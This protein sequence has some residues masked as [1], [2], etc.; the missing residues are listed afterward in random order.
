MEWWKRK[1][2]YVKKLTYNI[3][4]TTLKIITIKIYSASGIDQIKLCKSARFFK[5]DLSVLLT[6]IAI[7]Y[8]FH[9]SGGIKAFCSII[10]ELTIPLAKHRSPP[11]GGF[12]SLVKFCYFNF[13]LKI[14]S[15]LGR[16]YDIKTWKS[17]IKFCSESY[18]FMVINFA[19]SPIFS[20]LLR[21]EKNRIK[22]CSESYFFMLIKKW[23][24]RI[25]FCSDSLFFMVIKT[26]KGRIKICS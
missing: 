23:K 10:P 24:S 11:I 21:R 19:R 6:S 22:F 4:K 9:F 2:I 13:P 12:L 3:N 7:S 1:I 16:N 25:K 26:W 15:Y 17:R 18:F 14:W 8:Y 20:W 5:L